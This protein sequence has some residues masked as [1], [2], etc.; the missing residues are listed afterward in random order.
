MNKSKSRQFLVTFIPAFGIF[1]AIFFVSANDYVSA[2]YN[3][4]TYPTLGH[5]WMSKSSGYF[6]GTL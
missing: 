6:G 1:S 3:K 4:G 2:L 5:L